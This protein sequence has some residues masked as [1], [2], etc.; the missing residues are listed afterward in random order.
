MDVSTQSHLL[1]KDGVSHIFGDHDYTWLPLK[2]DYVSRPL[3]VT[4]DGHIIFEVFSLIAEKAIDFLATIAEPV[5]RPSHIHEYKLTRQSLYAAASV[6]LETD[7]IIQVLSRLSKAPIPENVIGLIRD[8]TLS[9]GKLRLVL[10]HGRYFVESSHPEM[11]QTL[12]RDPV[13]KE[14]RLANSGNSGSNITSAAGETP[15]TRAFSHSRE[16]RAV[17]LGLTT[18]QGLDRDEGDAKNYTVESLEIRS[19]SL[20]AV[21]KRCNDLDYPLS[22]EYDFRNDTLNPNLDIN[23][24]PNT[25]IRPYQETSLSKMF[26]NGRARSGIIVLPCRAGKTLVGITASST[27]KKSTL[28]LCTSSVSALQWKQQFLLWSNIKP[29]QT[30]LFTSDHKEKFIGKAGIVISTYSM[31]AS[32]GKRSH[33]SERMMNFLKSQEWGILLLDEVHVVPA[34]MFRKVLNTV[35]AHAKLG[36]TA[37]L[38]REDEKIEH[39]SYLI[40]PKLYEANWAELASKGHIANVQCAEVRCAMTPNFYAEYLQ[41]SSSRKRMLLSVMNPSKFQAYQFL[42]RY[43]EERGEK[44][45]VFSDDVYALKTYARMLGKPFICGETSQQERVQI[46]EHFQHDPQ[47]NAIFLSKVGDTSIDL[48]V[49][50]CLIQVSSHYG[51]RRQEAQRLGRILRAK[52]RNDEGFNAFFYTLV[53]EDTQEMYYSTKRQQ[54]LIDQ[55]YAFKVITELKGINQ[56][57]DLVYS[58]PDEQASLLDMVLKVQESEVSQSEV[59]ELDSDQL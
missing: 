29:N 18:V 36:L 17:G 34:D 44:I 59:M 43:H 26:G 10:K 21:K 45:I 32:T 40:G 13:I 49:A 5:S 31:V 38:V 27:I 1:Q 46:L 8:C 15:H 41:E 50:T 3:W 4:Q 51:S 22:E 12:L 30:A 56:E 48:P 23:L 9:Y 14:S 25:V 2:N 58:T 20:E 7:N 53:S 42:I 57:Q 6:G 54:F 55:G 47:I 35:V 33:D 19:S 24:K 52:R 37:T 28:V 39:L 16:S 11:L